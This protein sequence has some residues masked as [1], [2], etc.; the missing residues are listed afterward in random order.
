MD[1]KLSLDV[2]DRILTYISDLPTL[3]STIQVSKPIYHVFKH[4]P[5]S[6]VSAVSLNEIGPALPQ[7]M[8][9]LHITT[10]D[11]IERNLM[12]TE[13]RLPDDNDVPK[14][15][16]NRDKGAILT[17]NARVVRAFEDFFSQRCK[18]RTSSTSKLSEIESHRFHRA[19]YRL[20]LYQY[21]FGDDWRSCI[22][23]DDDQEMELVRGRQEYFLKHIPPAERKEFAAIYRFMQAT[24]EWVCKMLLDIELL[25]QFVVSAEPEV[26]LACI[27]EHDQGQ[28][29]G[30]GYWGEDFEQAEPTEREFVLSP[31]LQFGSD[32]EGQDNVDKK[33]IYKSILD[34]V[35]GENDT[36]THCG[37]ICG[38]DLWNESNWSLLS[39]HICPAEIPNLFPGHIL[40][41][42][43]ESSAIRGK[44]RSMPF[45][46]PVFMNAMFDEC[47]DQ[48]DGWSKQDWLCEQ[49]IRSFLTDHLCS[50]WLH[51]K[52]ERQSS[53]V[54]SL[55][56]DPHKLM[57]FAFLGGMV[58]LA[59]LKPRL[60]TMLDAS[61]ISASQREASWFDNSQLYRLFDPS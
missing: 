5:A 50:W 47:E 3:S 49:C 40:R 34:E 22:E 7:A 48:A 11:I 45:D 29:D 55:S 15:P 43:L 16:K 58:G 61:T 30:T 6:I 19:M 2:I 39:G 60:H 46:Y 24:S 36:C 38:L 26:L 23:N 14:Y 28:L 12:L 13:R 9:L 54:S 57:P 10:I 18:D 35:I 32:T 25:P 4:R 56:L 53:N 52:A 8:K 20:W 21:L 17:V 31:L 44:F 37:S 1:R 33:T 51:R 59:G 42:V 41:N 27:Q